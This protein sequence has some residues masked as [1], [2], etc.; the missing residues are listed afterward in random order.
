MRKKKPMKL[1][2]TQIPKDYMTKF[3]PLFKPS[4][5]AAGD[6]FMISSHVD[7]S[8]VT[9]YYPYFWYSPVPQL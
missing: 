6:T 2:L 1:I 5:L 8:D 3:P 7:F 4:P 9:N